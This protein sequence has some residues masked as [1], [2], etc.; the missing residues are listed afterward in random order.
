MDRD[1]YANSKIN[2]PVCNKLLAKNY[3]TSHL[4][5]VHR[6]CY[7]TEWWEK[8]AERLKKIKEDNKKLYLG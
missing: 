8:Y 1:S 4:K 2:C 3:L 6:N 7:G 5:S